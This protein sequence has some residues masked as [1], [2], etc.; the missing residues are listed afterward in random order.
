MQNTIPSVL[1]T[2]F[3]GF[4]WGFGEGILNH[5]GKTGG[6]VVRMSFTFQ[7]EEEEECLLQKK[8]GGISWKLCDVGEG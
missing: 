6:V 2:T 7:E 4:F 5:V 8:E 3:G 1:I